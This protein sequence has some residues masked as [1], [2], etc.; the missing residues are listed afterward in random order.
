MLGWRVDTNPEP[1]TSIALTFD[2]FD[3]AVEMLRKIGF[4]MERT[5]EEAW[6]DFRGWRVNYESTA[7]RLAD[8]L[9]APP[10]PWSGTRRHLR[11]GA[12]APRRPPQGTPPVL[13]G[14]RPPVVL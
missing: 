11:S 7:Y 10:A 9:V 13:S 4:P 6:D 14:H 1:G 2:E 5:A 8:R 12:V 3:Q